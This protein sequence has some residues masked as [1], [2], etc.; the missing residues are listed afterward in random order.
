MRICREPS[1]RG[2]Y[3][4]RN[5]ED[6]NAIGAPRPQ[7]SR[8]AWDALSPRRQRRRRANECVQTNNA[9]RHRPSPAPRRGAAKAL[10]PPLRPFRREGLGD[11]RI[12]RACSPAQLM[13][14]ESWAFSTSLQFAGIASAVPLV[15]GAVCP[16]P[17]GNSSPRGGYRTAGSFVIQSPD[18]ADSDFH[19]AIALE[20]KWG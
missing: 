11:R 16:V 10:T 12:G 1:S 8:G 4:A 20:T 3:L 2:R 6:L 18:M 9:L 14:H 17:S 15:G 5:P 7:A 13:I 19:V